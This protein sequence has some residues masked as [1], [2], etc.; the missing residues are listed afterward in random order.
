MKK[1]LITGGAGFIGSHVADRFLL[2]NYEVIAADN[3]VTGNVDNINGKNIKFFNIDI[4]DREKLEELFKNEQPDYVIHLAAQ[5]SVSSSVED[6]LYDAEEN[7][8]ALIN[9]LEL[10]KKYNTEKIVF[11]STAAVYGIPDEVPSRETNKTAPLSPYGLSKLT[12]EE[13]IK[14]YSRLFGVNYVI[15]R[16]ANVYGPRQSAHGEAGVVSIFNDKIKANGDI[17]IEGDGLQTRD[18]VYVKDVSGANY[19]CA[20]EDIKNETFNVSTNTDISILELFNTMKKY[21]GYEK[22]AFHKEARKGDI[23]NSRLDNNK[24]LKNTSWKP[25]YT[26]DQGLKEYL[27]K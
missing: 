9:I 5:V 23:R 12:G 10:C 3:L 7:I 24:L 6:V 1:V 19:I 25:E 4:R 16:Y 22:D 2:N 13:Y 17:F 14:M 27:D 18:F 20:T 15:L 8:T 11:S 21:S 26:L